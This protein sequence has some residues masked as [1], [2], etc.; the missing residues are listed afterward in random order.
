MSK[1]DNS[2]AKTIRSTIEKWTQSLADGNY[3][4]WI[5]F[6][7]EDAMLMPPNHATLNGRDEIM[8][9]ARANLAAPDTFSFKDWRIEGQGDYAVVANHILWGR[10]DIKQMIA[11]TRQADGWKIQMVM[12]SPDAA[13]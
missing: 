11:L 4:S 1:I 9:Y 5:G 6:W 8:S 3:E 13:T 10:S 7:T 12:F 2:T